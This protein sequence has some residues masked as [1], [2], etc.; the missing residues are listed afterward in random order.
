M[1]THTGWLID[2]YPD[3]NG[4]VLWLLCE[5]GLRPCLR[6]V[7]PVT[8]YA[9]GTAA[10]LDEDSRARQRIRPRHD[11]DTRDAAIER[12][13]AT[14]RFAVAGQPGEEG[15]IGR[16]VASAGIRGLG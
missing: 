10:W 11:L 8:F 14:N 7:F 5:D 9:A 2:L 16:R 3:E 4:V 13:A 6:M 15:I 12:D 1:Q